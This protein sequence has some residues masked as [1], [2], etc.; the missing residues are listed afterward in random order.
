MGEQLANR[1]ALVTGAGR[2]LGRAYALAL[3]RLGCSVVVNSRPRADRPTSHSVVEEIAAAGGRATAHVGCAA[4]VEGARQAVDAAL[5]AY[6]R[7]DILVLNAGSVLNRPFLETDVDDLRAMLDVHLVGPFAC[8]QRAIPAMRDQG[9][10]RIILTGSGSATFGL[11]N[12]AAYGSAKAAII[13]LCNVLRLEEPVSELMVNV[14][15]PVAPPPGRTPATA[16]VAELLGPY[17]SRLAPEWVAPLVCLLASPA[18][19]GT[20]GVYSAVAGR[21]ARIF[22][23]VG[24]GWTAT[25]A[26]PPSLAQITRHLPSILCEEQHSIPGSILE[27]I[28]AVA[29]AQGRLGQAEFV[30][31]GNL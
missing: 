6:G 19:P 15:L 1:V 31:A 5:Q 14:V 4:T 25:G 26:A 8:I 9:W 29:R 23:T 28:E 24:Q 3:A 11:E 21:Y 7:L 17:S 27:E 18:C 22:T 20:G 30:A 13:G 16:R 10:G 12:Q 2:G